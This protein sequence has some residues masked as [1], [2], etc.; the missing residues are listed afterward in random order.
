MLSAEDTTLFSVT[1]NAI[2]SDSVPPL[3]DIEG[4]SIS[5]HQ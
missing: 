2:R 4:S 5:D 3:P 1:A